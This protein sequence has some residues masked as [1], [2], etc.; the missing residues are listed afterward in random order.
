MMAQVMQLPSVLLGI[1]HIFSSN[2]FLASG[3]ILAAHSSC[4]HAKPR[5]R[6]PPVVAEQQPE[7]PL[8]MYVY[9]CYK[10]P[11]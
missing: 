9:Q 2:H 8:N 10:R 1:V 6:M 4:A 11:Q 3:I 5:R 7:L